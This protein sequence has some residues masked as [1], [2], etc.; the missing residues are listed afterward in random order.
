MVFC[1][2]MVISLEQQ[3]GGERSVFSVRLK[4]DTRPSSFDSEQPFQIA[5]LPAPKTC[6][7]HPEFVYRENEGERYAE[8]RTCRVRVGDVTGYERV[9]GVHHHERGVDRTNVLRIYRRQD[10]D[11]TG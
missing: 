7:R 5:V 6:E 11:E 8:C 1:I 9:Q 3:C 4:A 2:L 10:Y